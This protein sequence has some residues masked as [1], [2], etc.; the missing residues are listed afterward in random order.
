MSDPSIRS[1]TSSSSYA[2]AASSYSKNYYDVR[3]GVEDT[4]ALALA[5]NDIAVANGRPLAKP[6][7]VYITGH[8]MGGHVAA[9][10]V[11][12]GNAGPCQPP[13]SATSQAVPM[14]GVVG[15]RELFNEFGAMQ[16]AAQAL[17]GYT[18]TPRDQWAGAE[19]AAAATGQLFGTW[20]KSRRSPSCAHGGSGLTYL[21]IAKN[22][23]GGDRPMFTQGWAFGGSLRR[24]GAW[25]STSTARSTVY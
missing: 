23:T 18:A 3:A 13:G 4:N 16:M 7:K 9:A 6:V 14:C 1:A 20:T 19:A 17:T 11:E 2:W 5:F 10:A 15:D 25:R 12:Q 22:L 24:P 21:S 8:S